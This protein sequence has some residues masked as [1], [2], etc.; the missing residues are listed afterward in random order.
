MIWNTFVYGIYSFQRSNGIVHTLNVFMIAIACYWLFHVYT[1]AFNPFVDDGAALTLFS[2]FFAADLL[3]WLHM[4]GEIKNSHL[5]GPD[6]SYAPPSCR[7]K[8]WIRG[9]GLSCTKSGCRGTADVL[10]AD[11]GC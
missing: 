5:A 11:D 4:R 2:L 3:M 6:E 9:Y 7:S 8:R 10:P 1:G